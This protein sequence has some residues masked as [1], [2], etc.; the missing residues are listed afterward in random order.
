MRMPVGTWSRPQ[1][2][3][4]TDVVTG[5]DRAGTADLLTE[6][7]DHLREPIRGVG[8]AGPIL[9]VAVQW[10]IREHDAHPGGERLHDRLPLTVGEPE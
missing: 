7:R 4:G 10:Q 2:E 9:G 8:M 1:R 5:D 6:A 3:L